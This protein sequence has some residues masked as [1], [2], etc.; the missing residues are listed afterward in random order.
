MGVNKVILGDETLVDLTGDTV[1]KDKLLAGITA[2]DSNGELITGTAKT[3]APRVY[4]WGDSLTQGEGSNLKLT[5]GVFN[6]FNLH[7]YTA[8][9]TD[10]PV[11]NLGCQGEDITTIMARQGAD[12]MT[13]G[14]FTIPADCTPVVVG[15]K[16]E[17]IATVSGGKAKP[18]N[19][20]EAGINPCTIA[21][22]KGILHRGSS[23][24]NTD[25]NYYFTRLTPGDA[26]EVPSGSNIETFAMAYYRNGIAV[27]WMGANGGYSSVSDFCAKVKSMV[28]YGKYDDYL[29]LI[30]REFKGNYAKEV[31]NTLTDTEGVCHVLNLYDELPIHGLTLANMVHYYFDTSSYANGDEILLKAP[32]L[33]A[34][35]LENGSPKFES[36]HFSAYGYK[37]IGKLVAT[38]LA[39]I[40]DTEIVTPD[41]PV[42][43]E[44]PFE[45][46]V[47][48]S[49]GTMEVRLK[50]PYTSDG[51]VHLDTKWSPYNE[52]KNWTIAVKV[53]DG[54][55]G[56][57]DYNSI[58][59]SRDDTAG[60]ET[61]LHLRVEKVTE[62]PVFNI[63]LGNR[64]GFSILKSGGMF[65]WVGGDFSTDGYH[66]C[67]IAN[68]GGNYVIAFDGG[69]WD[70]YGA[71]LEGAF[72]E[73]TLCLFARRMPN[74]SFAQYAV[75]TIEDF[76][77]YNTAFT[78]AQ[79]KALITDMGGSIT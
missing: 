60:V 33:C 51:T 67:V 69:C 17:G 53:K 18:L 58:F 49:F 56:N 2:H 10:F 59:E 44:S 20:M 14:G 40:K 52:N 25:N 65:E 48:D 29:V 57:E 26:I 45:T 28:A 15:T 23:Q 47:T 54:I 35:T 38:R 79:C 63:G 75:G 73:D 62:T 12:P 5:D 9:L 78:A 64:K 11:I 32:M 72:T 8:E 39:A 76:R 34:C 7:P 16:I 6:S 68:N 43:P 50:S 66:Y 71:P 22:V 42:K 55:G 46:N 41:V 24:N 74:G 30:S 19:P 70:G 77:I 3:Q 37:A 1:T 31:A 61:T 36:L 21:G 27:I 4:C 13:V